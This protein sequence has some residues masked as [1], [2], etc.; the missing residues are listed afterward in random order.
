VQINLFKKVTSFL[1]GLDSYT[2]IALCRLLRKDAL[3]VC[4][5]Q[6]DCRRVSIKWTFILESGKAI[7][8]EREAKLTCKYTIQRFPEM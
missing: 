4:R 7:G 2:L 6:L 5:A 3:R 8:A 1:G